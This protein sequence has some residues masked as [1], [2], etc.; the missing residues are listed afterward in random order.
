MEA[1][2]GYPNSF[3]AVL[4]G[5]IRIVCTVCT[6]KTAVRYVLLILSESTGLLNYRKSCNFLSNCTIR[7]IILLQHDLR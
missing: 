6:Y 5:E 7:K 3:K 4:K 1:N 2:W